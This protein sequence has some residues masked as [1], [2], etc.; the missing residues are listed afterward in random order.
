MAHHQC[1][2]D[3]AAERAGSEQETLCVLDLVEIEGRHD[4]PAHQLQV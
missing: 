4:A 2:R 3:V 1:T